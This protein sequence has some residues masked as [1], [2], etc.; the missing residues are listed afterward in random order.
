M[1][2][3]ILLKPKFNCQPDSPLCSQEPAATP[4][5]QSKGTIPPWSL[6]LPLHQ[7]TGTFQMPQES[8]KPVSSVGQLL[9]LDGIPYCWCP[10]TDSGTGTTDFMTTTKGRQILERETRSIQTPCPQL[11]PESS[12]PRGG[13]WIH[14]WS[15]EHSV[16]HWQFITGNMN[17]EKK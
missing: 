9:E 1:A 14:L 10:P 5:C 3:L 15:G 6:F 4:V 17:E 12:S 16:H 8:H 2:H 13:S 11:P 7:H